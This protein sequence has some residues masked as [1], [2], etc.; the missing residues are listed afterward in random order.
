MPAADR[1]RQ[2]TQSDVNRRL[3]QERLQRVTELANA[4]PETLTSHI[5]E[6][7]REWDVER[8]LEA[9]ASTLILISLGLSRW[10]S[11]KWL[12]LAALVP[13]F[14]LQHAL[15]GW[16][17]PIEVIRRLGVRTRKEIDVERHALKALRGDFGGLDS[18]SEEP[19][20]L[21]QAAIEAAERA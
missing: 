6:L 11:R 15:Q 20:A 9:N 17:P 21:A 16:C 4:S 19:D 7:D 18:S 8:V 14:L 12:I 2:S 13:A 5:E 10:H 3:D 1:V